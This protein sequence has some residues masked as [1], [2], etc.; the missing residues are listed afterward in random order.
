MWI[1]KKSV[2]TSMQTI[3]VAKRPARSLINAQKERVYKTVVGASAAICCRTCPTGTKGGNNAAC[4]CINVPSDTCKFL[5]P[6]APGANTKIQYTSSGHSW[7]LPGIHRLG[8]GVDVLLL[9]DPL[10]P[11]KSVMAGHGVERQSKQVVLACP[12]S[13][14][15]VPGRLL[16][17]DERECLLVWLRL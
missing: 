7:S 11:T 4:E 1:P 16:R 5:Y 9:G 17:F 6:S 10:G 3:S 2:S 14:R 15:D 12:S 8:S 13:P